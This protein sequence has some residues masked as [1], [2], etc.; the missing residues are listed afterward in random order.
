MTELVLGSVPRG[1][2]YFGRENLIS[3]IKDSLTKNNLLFAA[4]RRFGKTGAMFKLLD[5]KSLPFKPI[6]IDIETITSPSDFMIEL[7][8][9]LL[10]DN[11][12]KKFMEVIFKKSKE[13]TDYFIDKASSVT[14]YDL[15]I[16]LR[17]R[18]DVKNDWLAY[19][20]KIFH[21]FEDCEPPIL[22]MIDE[23]AIMINHII[24]NKGVEEAR[25]FLHWFR[26]LR[27]SPE[28][29]ARFI[30]GSSIN[31]ED[32]LDSH[33]L[34]DTIN[35]LLKVKIEP[36][37]VETAK[38]FVK[39]ILKTNKVNADN[40]HIDTIIDLIG[41]PIPSVLALFLNSI[42]TTVKRTGEKITD[43]LIASIFESDLISGSSHIFRHYRSRIYQYYE[44][45]ETISTITILNQLSIAEEAISQDILYN[46]FLKST[47]RNSITESG[48]KF[49]RLM[50]KLEND[51]YISCV[52]NRYEFKSR[53]LKIW[54]K[55]DYGFQG[56]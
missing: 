3:E 4:P 36:F 46:T 18:T 54:W 28:T 24:E 30:I 37:D 26:K 40:T 2:D 53:A 45:D 33:S 13:L 10:K 11:H 47:G 6:Y 43:D 12:I 48:E 19:G 34:I 51:F 44:D 42:I 41:S 7:Y 8:A 27:Q 17:E 20:E 16:E 23:F 50:V 32:T 25:I 9:H 49:R 56:D 1:D 39:E 22:L 35:D 14:V 21:L 38:L 31:L 29:K 5:D 15:K 55:N 52:D